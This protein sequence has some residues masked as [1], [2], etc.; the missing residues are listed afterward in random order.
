MTFFDEEAK[1]ATKCHLCGG[2]PEC[3]QACPAGALRYVPWSDL[4]E[5][6]P[7]THVVPAYIAVPV[8]VQESCAVCH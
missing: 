1:K 7:E 5:A 2:N 6:I 4:T 8:G 3:V